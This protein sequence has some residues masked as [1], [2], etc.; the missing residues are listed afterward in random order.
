MHSFEMCVSVMAVKDENQG[1][2]P[3]FLECKEKCQNTE[4][5]GHK[6]L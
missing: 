3:T 4:L 5:M 1:E 2:A 6:T